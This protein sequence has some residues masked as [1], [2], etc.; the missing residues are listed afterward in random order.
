VAEERFDGS[1][2]GGD[3]EFEGAAETGAGDGGG[4]GF[5]HGLKGLVGGR[6]NRGIDF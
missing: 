2:T 6:K 5:R 1:D 4:G 3:H